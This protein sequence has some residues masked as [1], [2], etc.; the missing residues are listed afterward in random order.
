MVDGAFPFLAE[1]RATEEE[2]RSKDKPF[3][4]WPLGLTNLL[5]LTRPH[6]L[7]A[8]SAMNLQM[9]RLDPV[10]PSSLIMAIREGPNL[11]RMKHLWKGCFKPEPQLGEDMLG[12][13]DL[14]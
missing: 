9:M 14:A 12:S 3:K 11:L 13:N 10:I 6:L 5:P 8:Y 7:L 4:G 2:S 1:G